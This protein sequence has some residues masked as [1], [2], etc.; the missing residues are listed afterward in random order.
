MSTT[1]T[2]SA[3]MSVPHFSCELYFRTVANCTFCFMSTWDRAKEKN[4]LHVPL[5]TSAFAARAFSSSAVRLWHNLPATSDWQP[6]RL[7]LTDSS[8]IWTLISTLLRS[9]DITWL[10]ATAISISFNWLMLPYQLRNS[11]NNNNNLLLCIAT[12]LLTT[13]S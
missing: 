12:F 6:V 13:C 4:C 3:V 9:T 7:L 5:T 2:G 11:N 10:P 8:T 1:A